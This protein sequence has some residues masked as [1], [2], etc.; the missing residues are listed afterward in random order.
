[1][2]QKC[3]FCGGEPQ[4]KNK[5]HVIP[6][7]LSKYL[8]RY[9]SICDLSGV[10]DKK[11]PF[12]GLTFPA[13]EKCNSADSGLEGNA[14]KIVEKMMTGQ[15]V[16]GSEINTLLDWFDK[17][18]IGIWLGQLMLTKKIDEIDPNFY[19]NQ[20]IGLK[21]RMLIIERIDGVGNGLGLVG[22]NVDMFLTSPN[23]M[24]FWFND[25][26]ITCASATGLVGNK[27]GFPC[28]SQIERLGHR[29]CEIK[30]LPGRN[31]TTHPV[32]MNVDGKDKMI[33]YQ[34]IFKEYQDASYYDV[35]YVKEHCYD[36]DNGQ[37]GI[38]IQRNDNKIRYMNKE[39]KVNLLPKKQSK[40]MADN[41][42]KR[43]FELQNHIIENLY[44]MKFNNQMYEKY[45]AA[46]V[47]K[48]KQIIQ[49]CSR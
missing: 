17:L 37:G 13:C 31:K 43:V 47:K 1:M 2:A 14:K 35:P 12:S 48:N 41:S 26:L 6:Q 39:D 49:M 21:D 4:N 9:K 29:I 18:R 20:G 27:L 7:W 19:I 8:G 15:S 42:I 45:I 33:I 36:F 40:A 38:F 16:T 24:Q 5:E 30:V 22:S 32:V 11:I 23:V 44:K 3:V 25:V 28:V 10:T 46:C 34:P